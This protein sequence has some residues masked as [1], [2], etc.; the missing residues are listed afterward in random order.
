[1]RTRETQSTRRGFVK[2]VATGTAAIAVAGA[3]TAGCSAQTAKGSLES[4][5]E[6]LEKTATTG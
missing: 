4:K 5:V 6:A 2:E 3:I 1:M